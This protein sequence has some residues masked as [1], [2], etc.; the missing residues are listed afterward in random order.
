MILIVDDEARDIRNYVEELETADIEVRH[1]KNAEKALEVLAE[2]DSMAKLELVIL[3]I[4]MPGGVAF[5]DQSD[6]GRRTGVRLY[7]QIRA[8]HPNLPIIIFTNVPRDRVTE[9]LELD[10]WHRFL[11]KEHYFPHEFAEEV[12]TMLKKEKK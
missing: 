10:D 12:F 5:A 1:E 4:M 6:M 3:D 9:D 2:D 11:Q 8:S 7:K